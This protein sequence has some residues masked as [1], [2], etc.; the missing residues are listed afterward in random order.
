[1]VKLDLSGAIQWKKALG[2]SFS[3]GGNNIRQTADG[4]YIVACHSRSNNGDVTGNHG[5]NDAWIVKLAADGTIE[6]QKAYGSTK[7]EFAYSIEQTFDG[8][9]IFTGTSDSTGGDVTVNNGEEDFWV[10]KI[11]ATGSI[12]WE[13]S[14]GG[15]EEDIASVV[16]QTADSGYMVAGTT[17]S[18]DGDVTFNHG[19]KDVWV[20]K[21][22][23]TGA[24]QWQKTYGGT[25]NDQ[26]GWEFSPGA[27]KQIAGGYIFAGWT[28]STDGDVTVNH[29]DYDFWV[30][31]LSTI[32]NI[33]WQKT[34]GGSMD[35]EANAIQ[36]TSDGGYI[37][38]GV[39]QSSD[40]DV[41]GHHGGYDYWL[42]KLTSMGS[43]QWQKAMGGSSL[44]LGDCAFSVE[45]TTDHGIIVG[46]YSE[47]F[48]GDVTTP[49][50]T[51]DFWAV[52]LLCSPGSLGPS[53]VCKG[54]TITL[55]NP[56]IG[57]IWS[58]AST[59][60]ALTT[61][62]KVAGLSAG[63]AIVTYTITNACGV[64]LPMKIVTVNALPTPVISSTGLTMT[65][66]IQYATYQWYS[67]SGPIVGANDTTYTAASYGGT[68][69]VY[70][71]DSNGCSDTSAVFT[72]LVNGVVSNNV[73]SVAVYPN[74][75]NTAI[76][77]SGTGK[78]NVRIF[79]TVGSLVKD[80]LD[81]TVI[82]IADLA[83]GCYLVEVSNDRGEIVYRGTVMKQ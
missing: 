5:I 3:E 30:V 34:F 51:Y 1:V 78:N 48:D 82:D 70:V 80:R 9:Y 11:S 69:R 39:A 35:D 77:I 71:T 61:T 49:H 41:T 52:K 62:G 57:G 79:N 67:A 2:G 60:I 72:L 14:Y 73:Q 36:Q 55:T 8:G 29:G 26:V 76:Y 10:V 12:E 45:E 50:G 6:W 54:D 24:I 81:C 75:A 28:S 20:I 68:Y 83:L 53:E 65:T 63:T 17:I 13:K 33:A 37:V 66:T 7:N 59:N 32:G 56:A 19:N 58:T 25:G 44:G 31:K 4:G 47:S 46:G 64:S 42:V 23:K 18:S 38:A 21:L 43:L 40:G 15:S 74:P 22:S 27:L 16:I